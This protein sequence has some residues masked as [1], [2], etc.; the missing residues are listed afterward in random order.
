MNYILFIPRL[1]P[2]P[3]SVSLSAL[4][5]DYHPGAVK[6]STVAMK[7]MARHRAQPKPP[8]APRRKG[9]SIGAALGL[10]S[11]TVA[12]AAGLGLLYRL[13]DP[14]P[15][16]QNVALPRNPLERWL[17]VQQLLA[18]GREEEALALLEHTVATLP[19]QA[20]AHEQLRSV[21]EAAASADASA[22]RRL[23]AQLRRDPELH[24]RDDC[25]RIPVHMLAEQTFDEPFIIT[26]ASGGAPLSEVLSLRRLRQRY[27][28]AIV[29]H[30]DPSSLVA[31]GLGEQPTM[32]L[33]EALCVKCESSRT[34]N[35]G[36]LQHSQKR[37]LG[38]AP[39]PQ[40]GYCASSGHAWRLW[41]AQH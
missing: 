7:A 19:E 32:P 39:V 36:Q 27:G 22:A 25:S 20:A 26:A 34:R 21:L 29:K 10:A 6:V 12:I 1:W 40:L 31:N 15:Q 3:F 17:I 18:A 30:G 8:V 13:P 5:V 37:R 14:Q 33:G 38:S 23:N 4:F 24:T 28:E 16:P 35:R 2:H 11:L 41:T 9:G